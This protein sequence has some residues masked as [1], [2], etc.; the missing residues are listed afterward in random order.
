MT[1]MINEPGFSTRPAEGPVTPYQKA[2]QVWDERIG[3]A[4]LQARNWRLMAFGLIFI[5]MIL[6]LML[7]KIASQATVQPYIVKVAERG[8]VMA[9]ESVVAGEMKLDEAMIRYFLSEVVINMR[10]LPLD[11]VVAKNNWLT[12]Y[13]FLSVEAQTRMNEI[14]QTDDPFAD[15]GERTRSIHMESMVSLSD[16]T[17]QIRWSEST[18]AANGAFIS[19]EDYTGVFTYGLEPPKTAARLQL[20]PLGLV[21]THFDIGKDAE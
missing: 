14:A 3:S 6:S 4:R 12:V 5:V 13:S 10:S 20:N 7:A 16:N 11:P 1:D 2:A 19:R 21:I 17:R 15:L 9:V 18:F 8:N